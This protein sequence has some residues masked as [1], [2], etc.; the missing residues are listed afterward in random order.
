MTMIITE[1]DKKNITAFSEWKLYEVA[2][3]LC[4]YK[5]IMLIVNI[6]LSD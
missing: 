5:F 4:S 1:K 6:R 3:I 2:M